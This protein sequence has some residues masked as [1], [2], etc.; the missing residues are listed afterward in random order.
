MT[1]DAR[2]GALQII[3]SGHL[4]VLS[5]IPDP[6]GDTVLAVAR[7]ESHTGLRHSVTLDHGTVTCSAHPEQ[8]NAQCKHGYALRLVTGGF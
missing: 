2:T 4:Q 8:P 6:S 7:V 3:R 1:P 5:A